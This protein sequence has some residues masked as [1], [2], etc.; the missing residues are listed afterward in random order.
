MMANEMFKVVNKL[1]PEYI[2]DLINIKI[3]PYNFRGERK[4]YLARFL[5][6]I[7]EVRERLICQE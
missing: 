5:H 1:S 4:A 7:S 3:F 2:Q 6:I